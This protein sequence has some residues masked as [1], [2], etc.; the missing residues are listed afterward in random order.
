MGQRTI[1]NISNVEA[2]V[3]ILYVYG[4]DTQ[5][6]KRDGFDHVITARSRR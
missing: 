4:A 2:V 6:L 1:P 5:M 3:E